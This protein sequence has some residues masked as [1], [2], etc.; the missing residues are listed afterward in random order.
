MKVK[1]NKTKNNMN[2]VKDIMLK[3]STVNVY[4]GKNSG[5]RGLF[6]KI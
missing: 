3:F 1:L 5:R 2:L 4:D 6:V